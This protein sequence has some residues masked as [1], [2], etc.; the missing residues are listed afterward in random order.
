MNILSAA[1]YT[2]KVF[3][4]PE[5]EWGYTVFV[6]SLPGCI[7]HGETSEQAIENAHEAIIAY[8]ESCQKHWEAITDDSSILEYTISIPKTTPIVA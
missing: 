5:S 1:W 6:P 3:L 2:F 4:R 7:T 8:I